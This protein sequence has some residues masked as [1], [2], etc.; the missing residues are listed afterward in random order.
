MFQRRGE[1]GRH[2][3]VMKQWRLCWSLVGEWAER[4]G[5]VFSVAAAVDSMVITAANTIAKELWEASSYLSGGFSRVVIR[6]NWREKNNPLIQLHSPVSVGGDSVMLMFS[7]AACTDVFSRLVLCFEVPD[8]CITTC[9]QYCSVQWK[10]NGGGRPII[11]T[12]GGKLHC[13]KTI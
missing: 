1:R 5:Y 6:L 9:E 3:S 10:E 7:R 13:Q 8:S 12:S 4:W 11:Q 2:V